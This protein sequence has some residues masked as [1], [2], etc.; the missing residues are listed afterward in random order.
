MDAAFSIFLVGMM[1]AGK[2]TVGVRLARK[3]GRTFV[4]A[5]RAL[6]ERLGVSIPT[7]FELEG[8]AGFRRRET[9]FLEELSARPGLVL[10]TGGGVVLSPV[11]R[12][13]LKS[14]GKAIYLQA[15]PADLWQRLRRDRQ[16]PLLRTANPRER[17]YEL[18]AE[19]DALYREVAAYTV[20]TSRQPIDQ[21]VDAVIQRLGETDD[22]DKD[23]ADPTR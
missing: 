4:D 6:E 1:G 13:L 10:A 23:H 20:T 14:R 12:E 8:E 17:I 15:S 2:S 22:G 16:R 9:Q 19:R 18:C 11:N 5:D 7:I 21:I 3:L